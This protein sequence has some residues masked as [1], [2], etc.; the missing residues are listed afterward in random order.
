MK[1]QAPRYLR[2]LILE[3]VI[4][5]I[6]QKIETGDSNSSIPIMIGETMEIIDKIMSIIE[7][8]LSKEVEEV[9]DLKVISIGTEETIK[10]QDLQGLISVPM[11]VLMSPLLLHNSLHDFKGILP[12][13]QNQQKPI[14]L[15]R[16]TDLLL[17]S[18]SYPWDR[19]HPKGDRLISEAGV[20]PIESKVAAVCT[21][22]KLFQIRD[23]KKGPQCS[24]NHLPIFYQTNKEILVWVDRE[25]I[26]WNLITRE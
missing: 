17:D 25:K 19:D 14:T 1:T 20:H 22:D 15:I 8:S 7:V 5:Q 6:D 18:K 23:I 13:N 11:S 2:Q 3:T 4:Q 16:Q 21:I 24:S 10:L 26:Q 12:M 9:V